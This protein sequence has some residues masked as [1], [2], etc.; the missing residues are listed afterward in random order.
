VET[1]VFEGAKQCRALESEVIILRQRCN[2]LTEQNEL[3]QQML[4]QFQQKQSNLC[5]RVSSLEVQQESQ[6][7]SYLVICQG[8]P[9][10]SILNSIKAIFPERKLNA[11]V[12]DVFDML[13]A[14]KNFFHSYVNKN[15]MLYACLL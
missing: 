7:K 8:S 9:L 3:L 12:K 1:A 15:S 4:V 13:H 5:S 11:A 14:N 6:L 2:E 10:V